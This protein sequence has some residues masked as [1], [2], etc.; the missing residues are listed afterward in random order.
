MD[1]VLIGV[2]GFC[3]GWIGSDQM[4]RW[5]G[6]K[7]QELNRAQ[8]ELIEQIEQTRDR[9]FLH[10]TNLRANCFIPNE[11]GHKVRYWDASEQRRAKAEGRD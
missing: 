3:A 5:L 8:A 1:W 11:K 6:R 7:Q 4:W 2:I 9:A 10:L